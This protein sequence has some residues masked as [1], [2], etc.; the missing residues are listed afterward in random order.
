[1]TTSSTTSSTTPTATAATPATTLDDL[2]TRLTGR[3]VEPHDADYDALRTVAAG[4]VDARPAAIVR[5][6]TDDDVVATLAFVR[7]TG[8]PVAVRCGGHSSAAHSTVDGGVVIDVRDL[9]G[10]EVDADS[11][12]AWVGAGHTAREVTAALAEHGLAVGFGDTGEV[13]VAGITLGGGIGFLSRA[14]GLTIDNLL[15]ADVVTADGRVLRTDAANHPDLFWGLRGA[16][17][18]L[19]VVTRLRF[20]VHP[21]RDVVGGML[22]L[23]ATAPVLAG[24]VA[25]AQAAPDELGVIVNVMP[26]PPLPFVPADVHGRLVVMA[27]VCWSGAAEDADA[28]LAPIRSLAEPIADLV[29]PTPYAGMFPPD[30]PPEHPTVV[31]R[32]LFTDVVDEPLAARLLDRLAEVDGMRV[33]QLRVLGGAIARVPDDATAYAHRSARV[34]AYVAAFVSPE[35][36]DERAAWVAATAAALDRGVPGVYVNFLGEE[37]PDRVRDAYPGATW[38]RIAQV[39]ATYDPENLF[40]RNQNVPPAA[41]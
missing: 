5:P 22:L 28:V 31:A 20:R 23:P 15:G 35:D 14:H 40:R 9:L 1:M 24:L 38:D 39:K 26:C 33:A 6:A 30:A 8:I 32:G 7:A 17:A 37:G 34:M 11:G 4:G 18:N 13:G 10:I 16:G 2:R 12:T 3:V 19:G 41:V 25:A 21:V 36:R 27:L 29:A